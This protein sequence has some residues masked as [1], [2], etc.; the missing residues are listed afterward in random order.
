MARTKKMKVRKSEGP[1][2]FLTKPLQKRGRPATGGMKRPHR[3]HLGTVALHQIR[4]FQMSTK[5]LIRKLPF[6]W[7]V[8]EILQDI[9]RDMCLTPATVL[10]LQE[11]AEAFLVRL[12]EGHKRMCHTCQEGYHN[13]KGHEAGIENLGGC[14]SWMELGMIVVWMLINWGVS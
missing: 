14:K 6:L 8:R 11:A 13:A 2:H 7:L 9:R 4:Q 10:A 1:K 3:F 12:F 5:L